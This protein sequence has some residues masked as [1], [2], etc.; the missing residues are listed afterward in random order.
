MRCRA[1]AR[2]LNWCI[3]VWLFL[4]HPGHAGLLDEMRDGVC[5]AEETAGSVARGDGG[6]GGADH[7]FLCCLSSFRYTVLP[8]GLCFVPAGDILRSG[9]NARSSSPRFDT[10]T[11]SVVVASGPDGLPLDKLPLEHILDQLRDHVHALPETVGTGLTANIE[12]CEE[13]A[14]RDWWRIRASFVNDIVAVLS[15]QATSLSRLCSTKA[16]LFADH[17]TRQAVLG[18]LLVPSPNDDRLRNKTED[19]GRLKRIVLALYKNRTEVRAFGAFIGSPGQGKTYIMRL[20][21]RSSLDPSFLASLDAGVRDWWAGMPIHAISYN[22]RTPASHV[23]LEL[24]N[25]DR[26]LPNIVRLLFVEIQTSVHS[27]SSWSTFQFAMLRMVSRGT[28]SI[29]ILLQLASFVF[30]IRQLQGVR[31]DDEHV[32]GI[33]L[34]DEL[35]RVSNKLEPPGDEATTRGAPSTPSRLPGGTG[36]GA[37]GAG[38]EQGCDGGGRGGVDG[39][40]GRAVAVTGGAS[41]VGSGTTVAGQGAATHGT[42]TVDAGAT[43]GGADASSGGASARDMD[44]VMGDTA[45][46]RSSPSGGGDAAGSAGADDGGNALGVVAARSTS[47]PSSRPVLP[48]TPATVAWSLTQGERDAEALATGSG[49]AVPA[50]HLRTALCGLGQECHVFMCISSLSCSFVEEQTRLPS[51]SVQVNLGVQYFMQSSRVCEAAVNLM[52]THSIKFHVSRRSDDKGILAAEEV[53]RCLGTLASGHP[54]AAV[55]LLRAMEGCDS[56]NPFFTSFMSELRP[57]RLSIASSS[58]DMLLANPIVVAVGLLGYNPEPSDDVKEGLSWD[59]IYTSGA[60]TRTETQSMSV[61]ANERR[62]CTRSSTRHLRSSTASSSTVRLNLS[63]LLEALKRKA[64]LR[65]ANVSHKRRRFNS[66]LD[67]DLFHSLE[68]VRVSFE[69][70]EV[71]VAWEEFALWAI[72]SVC[73]AG[74]VCL[75]QLHPSIVKNQRQGEHGDMSLLD[76]FPASPPFVGKAVWLES[77]QMDAAC[78]RR[79]VKLFDKLADLLQKDEAALQ[80]HVWKPRDPNFPAFDGLIFMKCTETEKTDGPH[81]GDLVAVMLQLKYKRMVVVEKDIKESCQAGIKQFTDITKSWNDRVAFVVL[82]RQEQT[83]DRVVDLA[84]I[85]GT[86][87]VILVD[88]HDLVSVFGPCLYGFLEAAPIL[89]GTQVLEESEADAVEGSGDVGGDDH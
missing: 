68:K 43:T 80:E 6:D 81:V 10:T 64:Q 38:G 77:A 12:A 87:T 16:I 22:G 89:F 63:F 55:L 73:T 72:S 3:F 58:I 34:V 20:L 46:R 47:A 48:A 39:G 36:G 54:R 9:S 67:E 85:P 52:K 15:Q 21:V 71:A 30:K 50:R 53:G 49:E 88:G 31:P 2:F 51:G 59:A 27:A 65:R 24:F 66:A 26:R 75:T 42:I 37:V 5:S 74:H 32:L 13:G 33:L 8:I 28:E 69:K 76:M 86:S 19:D 41:T 82:S 23:D 60:L 44:A 57:A 1:G 14:G 4:L 79:G 40:S 45:A 70:G 17:A 78:H 84:S 7:I 25:L 62:P 18:S 83:R 61:D 35:L 29:S 56:G 11:A